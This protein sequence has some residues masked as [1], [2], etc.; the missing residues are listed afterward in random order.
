MI[1]QGWTYEG[2]RN[3]DS[4]PSRAGRG[5]T[6]E[7]TVSSH[8]QPLSTH[9]KPPCATNNSICGKSGR[10]GV[11]I[12]AL[13]SLLG[14]WLVCVVLRSAG[15]C[16]G[17]QVWLGLWMQPLCPQPP[18][19]GWLSSCPLAGVILGRSLQLRCRKRASR[20]HCRKR[21][22]SHRKN[23][24]RQEAGRCHSDTKKRLYDSQR[25][26]KGRN[27]LPPLAHPACALSLPRTRYSLPAGWS[28][29]GR[30]KRGQ[31]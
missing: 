15:L 3:L 21:V 27:R 9:P 4:H 25:E 6:G 14:Q 5:L 29:C 10:P 26:G 18:P 16:P 11:W 12:H 13:A 19:L 30:G 23:Y 22:L 20:T 8:T 31:R 24:Q 1:H 2:I 28:N 7:N 17:A